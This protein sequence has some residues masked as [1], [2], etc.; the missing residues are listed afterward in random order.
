MNR[1]RVNICCISS[2]AEA[3]RAV[4]RGVDAFGFVSELPFGIDNV[5]NSDLVFEISSSILPTVGVANYTL[6]RAVQAVPIDSV[7]VEET[8]THF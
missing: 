6:T 3:E 5:I 2:V 4:S 7:F 1:T 8:T